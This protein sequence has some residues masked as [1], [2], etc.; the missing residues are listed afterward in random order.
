[1]YISKHIFLLLPAVLVLISCEGLMRE[2]EAPKRP[3]QDHFVI[4]TEPHIVFGNLENAF[5]YREYDVYSRCFSDSSSSGRSFHFEPAPVKA[6][7]FPEE[8]TVQNEVIYFQ[9]LLS[10]TPED[11]LLLLE[12]TNDD[13]PANDE[14][15]SVSYQIDY[16]I[17]AQH[18][19]QGYDNEFNGRSFVKLT[20]NNQN[21]WVI[22]YWQDISVSTDATWS[23][24][25]A[26][27][28]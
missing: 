3:S 22:Y 25:K 14:G 12:I 10:A 15:D 27:F 4:P 1:M 7:V 28:Y 18:S 23:D 17:I 16:H 24:L 9:E 5:S 13:I 6:V 20:R 2:A 26:Y 21:Y 19:R 8:W 11:S